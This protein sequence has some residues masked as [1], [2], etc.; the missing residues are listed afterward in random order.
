MV[1]YPFSLLVEMGR[2]F[3]SQLDETTN[4][5]TIFPVPT[6]HHPKSSTGC[7]LQCPILAGKAISEVVWVGWLDCLL[8]CLFLFFVCAIQSSNRFND[9]FN[10]WFQNVNGIQVV[11]LQPFYDSFMI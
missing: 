11:F 8:A 4:W 1:L 2:P 10:Q 3:D 6:H 9:C 5:V 7:F